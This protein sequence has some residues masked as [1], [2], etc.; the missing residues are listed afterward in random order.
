MDLE[1]QSVYKMKRLFDDGKTYLKISLR[2]SDGMRSSGGKLSK[3][4]MVSGIDSC[5]STDS[6]EGRAKRRKRMSSIDVGVGAVC[7]PV[8]TTKQLYRQYDLT[9]LADV[10]DGILE[11]LMLTNDHSQEQW[12]QKQGLIHWQAQIAFINRKGGH[13]VTRGR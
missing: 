8:S 10:L 11:L 2:I 13:G 3:G 6:F 5:F 4:E 12:R 7:T 1:S 9:F